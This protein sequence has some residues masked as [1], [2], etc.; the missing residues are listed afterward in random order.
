MLLFFMLGNFGTLKKLE[1]EEDY[2]P[3]PFLLPVESWDELLLLADI[4]EPT[5]RN[6][7]SLEVAKSLSFSSD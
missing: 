5:D 1:F 3:T 4:I 2:F 7:E 6:E